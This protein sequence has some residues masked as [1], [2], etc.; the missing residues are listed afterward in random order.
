MVFSTS[1]PFPF[2]QLP[3]TT[4]LSSVGRQRQLCPL[5]AASD[6]PTAELHCRVPRVIKY[7]EGC[8]GPLYHSQKCHVLW[9]GSHWA[10]VPASRRLWEGGNGSFIK[11]YVDSRL[12]VSL[13]A[14]DRFSR[15]LFKKK[16][17]NKN[18]TGI[19]AHPF[20]KKI[21]VFSSHCNPI[22]KAAACPPWEEPDSAHTAKPVG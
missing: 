8:W 2:L 12:W 7:A 10:L 21:T 19:R 9:V 15:F 14:I 3:T 13:C 18:C 1:T 6:V 22:L 17:L 4:A 20:Q 16:W 11:L 5:L